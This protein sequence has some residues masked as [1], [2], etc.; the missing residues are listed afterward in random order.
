MSTS[1]TP[2]SFRN[3]LQMGGHDREESLVI[4][5]LVGTHS[6]QPRVLTLSFDFFLSHVP[7]Y[8]VFSDSQSLISVFSLFPYIFWQPNPYTIFS[9]VRTFQNIFIYICNIPSITIA[10]N[11]C[12]FFFFFFIHI[13]CLLL[14]LLWCGV[15][16]AREFHA[17]RD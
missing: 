6:L 11:S 13:A 9:H 7:F 14:V 3:S 8:L 4:P 15:H 1:F 17:T 5:F 12:S 16:E 2:C 10:H